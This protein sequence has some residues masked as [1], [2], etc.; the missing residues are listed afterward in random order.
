MII[1]VGSENKIKID[2]VKEVVKEYMFLHKSTI[3]SFKPNSEVSEQPKSME[4]ILLGAINRAKNSFKNCDYSIGI[5]DGLMKVP[6]IKTG[7]MNLGACIIYDGKNI[8][9]GCTPAYE[10]DSE[11]IRCIFE[12]NMT[13]NEAFYALRFTEDPKLGSREGAIGVLTHFRTTRKEQIKEGLRMA[14]IQLDR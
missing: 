14:L 4:E 5:E 1:N 9:P 7:Y 6:Y 13:V 2:A 11:I 10:Y 12:R 8:F 3:I